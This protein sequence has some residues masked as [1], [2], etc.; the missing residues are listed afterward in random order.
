MGD[1]QI[2]FKTCRAR[3]WLRAD[4]NPGDWHTCHSL[5]ICILIVFKATQRRKPL[6]RNRE[7][8]LF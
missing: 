6:Y 5:D 8:L 7:R 4:G 2:R 3:Y 1:C